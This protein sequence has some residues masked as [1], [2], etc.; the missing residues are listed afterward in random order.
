MA[1]S[2]AAARSTAAHAMLTL[3]SEL[4]PQRHDDR[5]QHQQERQGQSRPSDARHVDN[6]LCLGGNTCHQGLTGRERPAPLLGRR[7]STSAGWDAWAI[8]LR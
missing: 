3:Q 2:C 4:L 1:N 8:V 5:N 6:L 7:L